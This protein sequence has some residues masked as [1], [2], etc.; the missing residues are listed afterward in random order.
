MIVGKMTV[1]LNFNKFN[2]KVCYNW[3]FNIAVTAVNET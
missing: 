3:T 1:Q 2:I